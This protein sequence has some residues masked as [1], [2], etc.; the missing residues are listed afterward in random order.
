LVLMPKW[1]VDVHPDHVRTVRNRAHGQLCPYCENLASRFDA[2][3]PTAD[4][5]LCHHVPATSGRF[6]VDDWPEVPY[7][8]AHAANLFMGHT[9]CNEAAGA[10]GTI[11]GWLADLYELWHQRGIR[12]D[13]ARR[14]TEETEQ[15]T[16]VG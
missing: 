13:I 1:K 11:D 9:G 15:R 12:Q 2:D 3:R 4:W 6:F 7:V 14:I 10:T 16:S 8:I 5:Q